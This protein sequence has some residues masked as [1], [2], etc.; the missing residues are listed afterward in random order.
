MS[1]FNERCITEEK[2]YAVSLPQD[3]QL[4]TQNCNL[5]F[6]FFCLDNWVH[7]GSLALLT[8]ALAGQLCIPHLRTVFSSMLRKMKFSTTRPM[9]ITENSP[10]NTLAISGRFL[11]S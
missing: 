5:S 10:A 11:F 9:M 2:N 4:Q 3:K 1:I 8:P 6:S 7:L